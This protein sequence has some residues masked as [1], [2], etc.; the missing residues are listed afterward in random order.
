MSVYIYSLPRVP[1]TRVTPVSKWDGTGRTALCDDRFG[2]LAYFGP[3]HDLLP[4]HSP[5]RDDVYAVLVYH[6][7]VSVL[8]VLEWT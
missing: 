7:A 2:L 4:E 6:S 1:T 3:S 5:R 8:L